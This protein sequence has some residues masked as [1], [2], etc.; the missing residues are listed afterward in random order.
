MKTIQ[1]ITAVETNDWKNKDEFE[2]IESFKWIDWT[3]NT[4][5]APWVMIYLQDVINKDILSVLNWIYWQSENV[6]EFSETPNLNNVN[7]DIAVIKKRIEQLIWINIPVSKVDENNNTITTSSNCIA[8]WLWIEIL[9]MISEWV[10]K[11][12]IAKYYEAYEFFKEWDI[13]ENSQF[14]FTS[15]KKWWKIKDFAQIRKVRV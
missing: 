8:D 9:K 13:T 12:T 11:E 1:D 14:E 7:G 6:A 3:E 4:A 10:D 2:P 5:S 15:P